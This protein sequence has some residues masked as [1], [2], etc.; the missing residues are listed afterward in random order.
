MVRILCRRWCTANLQRS[1]GGWVKGFIGSLSSPYQSPGSSFPGGEA[2]CPD[3]ILA[4]QETSR[5]RYRLRGRHGELELQTWSQTWD[6]AL[7][8]WSYVTI[9]AL[10]RRHGEWYIEGHDEHVYC[11]GRREFCDYRSR[12]VGIPHAFLYRW[13]SESRSTHNNTHFPLIQPPPD[14][15]LP[16]LGL[17]SAEKFLPTVW[18]IFHSQTSDNWHLRRTIGST[19]PFGARVDVYFSTFKTPAPP[20]DLEERVSRKKWESSNR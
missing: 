14:Y 3:I 2:P 18:S 20:L 13:L 12:T 10:L 8:A 9:G 19:L 1:C 7:E 4:P 15:F 6:L 5:S 16:T 11:L 17:C